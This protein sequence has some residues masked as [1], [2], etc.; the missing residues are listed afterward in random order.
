[1]YLTELGCRLLSNA[2]TVDDTRLLRDGRRDGLAK[3][4]S[5][6]GVHLLRLRGG[7]D[8]ACSDRPDRFIRDN[9]F[10]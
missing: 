7:G 3:I 5:D 10:A 6:C 4:V 2:T 1:M 9:Y 8:L